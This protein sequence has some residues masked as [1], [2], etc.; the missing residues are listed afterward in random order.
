LSSFFCVQNKKENKLKITL[1]KKISLGILFLMVGLGVTQAQEQKKPEPKFSV[2]LTLNQDAFFGFYPSVNA[3]MSLSEK[4]DL[5]FYTILWT[6]P[7]FGTGGGGGLW[8]EFGAGLNLRAAEGALVISPSIGILNGKLLSNG[9]YSMPF[10]GIVS[11]LTAN[12]NT[13]RFEGQ[14]YLG[15]Y[16]AMRKGQVKDG[17]NYED[18][19]VQNN[20]LH[21]WI[22][23]G[24]KMG[25]PISLGLHFEHLRSNPSEGASS[26]VYQWLGPYVQFT[27]PKGHGLRFTG[28]A[29]IT[30]RT[31]DTEQ[32]GFYKLS[33][34]FNL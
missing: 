6:T 24:V 17:N 5:T 30:S 29:D 4:T 33:A 9:S 18:A 19:R 8:T 12:L 23:A 14:F 2:N 11:S 15:Y 22:N 16:A 26:D 20:F 34:F 32:N 3:S 31:P 13:R 7:S 27:T 28:G 10:E 25:I 1:M 21:Y